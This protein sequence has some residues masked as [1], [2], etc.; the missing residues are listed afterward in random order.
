MSLRISTIRIK[1]CKNGGEPTFDWQKTERFLSA[2]FSLSQSLHCEIS[3]YK[4]ASFSTLHHL[5][6]P[7]R[8]AWQW[9]M[10]PG[11][12]EKSSD[13]VDSGTAS[14]ADWGDRAPQQQHREKKAEQTRQQRGAQ[15]AGRYEEGGKYYWRSQFSFFSFFFY[16]R[17][18]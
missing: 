3:A 16:T 14:P 2:L 17:S 8:R 5:H 9:K 15:Q 18:A 6:R 13:Q 11:L 12:C 7:W 10:L 1:T 4:K